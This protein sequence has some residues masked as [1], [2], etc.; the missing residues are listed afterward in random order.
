MK[1]G[2]TLISLYK[3]RSLSLARLSRMSGVPT[4]TLHGWSIGKAAAKI[5][6]HFLH[7]PP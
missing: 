5:A 6:V 7:R 4:Q 3:K 1:L 2:E